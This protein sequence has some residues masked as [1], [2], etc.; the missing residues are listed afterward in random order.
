MVVD[1]NNIEGSQRDAE[2]NPQPYY[3]MHAI[4]MRCEWVLYVCDDDN[5]EDA[6]SIGGNLV[7]V[8]TGRSLRS[9]RV[10]S[11]GRS[12][13][14]ATHR[15]NRATTFSCPFRYSQRMSVSR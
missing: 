15:V 4:G 14:L 1:I 5:D 6:F 12:R 11:F 9:R 2:G 7:S 10:I 13:E 3:D 8:R